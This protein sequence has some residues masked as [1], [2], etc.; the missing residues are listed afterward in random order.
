[1]TLHQAY[2]QYIFSSK[3]LGKQII[4]ANYSLCAPRLSSVV[5]LQNFV[6]QTTKE[7]KHTQKVQDPLLKK[8]FLE[9]D[10]REIMDI[11]C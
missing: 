11:K 4:R 6:K 3:F 9:D 5:M 8:I 1:M 10:Y 7:N 2:K